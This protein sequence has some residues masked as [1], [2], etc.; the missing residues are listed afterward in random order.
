MVKEGF[1]KV[2]Q[3]GGSY[4]VAYFFN[5]VTKEEYSKCVRDY[6]YADCSRDDDELY[7]MEINE[8]V[9]KQWLHHHGC[10]LIG[11]TVKVVKGRKI[12]TGTIARVVK[13]GEFRDRYGRVQTKYLYFE[14]G[15][16]TSVSNCILYN[17]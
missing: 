1:F 14:D 10:I 5:P 15:T 7:H 4:V 17:E 9:R 2:S 16:R 6:D 13:Y 11:D 12:P 8:N 3:T